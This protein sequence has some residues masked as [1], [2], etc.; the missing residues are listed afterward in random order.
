M[1]KILTIIGALAVIVGVTAYLN[2]GD[3]AFKK[4]SQENAVFL[5]KCGGQEAK[6][7]MSLV[8]SLPKVDFEANIKKSGKD[9]VKHIFTGAPLR[10]IFEA[11]NVSFDGKEKVIVKAVDGYTSA[12]TM[13]EAMQED[14]VYIVYAIDNKPLGKKEDGGAGP[15]ELVIKNDPFSQRWCKFVSEVEIQ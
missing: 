15:F 8:K 7:D 12:I 4:E 11:V 6:V 2:L 3:L 9:P 1:K 14:N 5:I 10:K 13:D